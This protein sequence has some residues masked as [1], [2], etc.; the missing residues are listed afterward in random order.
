MRP[1]IKGATRIYEDRVTS[2]ALTTAEMNMEVSPWAT[3]QKDGVD[4]T[5]QGSGIC[6]SISL[7]SSEGLILANILK[8]LCSQE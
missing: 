6:L 5:I 3:P 4:I 8:G 1:E 2:Y 7:E